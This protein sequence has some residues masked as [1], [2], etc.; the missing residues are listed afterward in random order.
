MRNGD[1]QLTSDGARK[2]DERRN[3]KMSEE[4]FVLLSSSGRSCLLV[5]EDVEGHIDECT[6]LLNF[7]LMM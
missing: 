7:A 2:S 5:Q 3:R 1:E 6:F 4:K